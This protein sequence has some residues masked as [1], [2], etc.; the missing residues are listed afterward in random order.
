MS[1]A[2]TKTERQQQNPS[3]R[4]AGLIVMRS[5][6]GREQGACF[7]QTRV[8]VLEDGGA[9]LLTLGHVKGAGEHTTLARYVFG[10]QG[11]RREAA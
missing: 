2:R 3:I 1:I 9:R 8:F 7:R 11:Q 4:P 6:G 10:A 5:G